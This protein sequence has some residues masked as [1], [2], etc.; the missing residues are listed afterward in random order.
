MDRYQN[1]NAENAWSRSTLGLAVD[2]SAEGDIK[3]Y[4][5]TVYR[6]RYKGARLAV[7]IPACLLPLKFF[8]AFMPWVC[9]LRPLPSRCWRFFMTHRA[10]TPACAS[11]PNVLAKPVC[12]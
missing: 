3:L 11:L 2:M 10:A 1:N 12:G 5:Y 9:A 6:S 8:L 4:A 7:I